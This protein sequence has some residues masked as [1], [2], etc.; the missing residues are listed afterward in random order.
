MEADLDAELEALE[1][2]LAITPCED[3]H[4]RCVPSQRIPLSCLLHGCLP[5]IRFLHAQLQC[6]TPCQG[7]QELC[8]DW[9]EAGECV[10]NPSF[11]RYGCRAACALC[12]VPPAA[13]PRWSGVAWPSPA[14]KPQGVGAAATA[15]A[16]A[17][18][19]AR[20]ADGALDSGKGWV[21]F[22][23]SGVEAR[24]VATASLQ[25]DL[26]LLSTVFVGE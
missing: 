9:A 15:G 6:I 5:C 7:L 12:A 23:G 19:K 26:A 11:M 17:G 8:K 24:A 3:T 4:V 18:V 22:G 20:R 10:Q 25:V 13:T 2:E 16:A 14:E 21:T 1:L